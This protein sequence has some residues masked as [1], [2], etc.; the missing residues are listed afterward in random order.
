LFRLRLD[1]TVGCPTTGAWHHARQPICT[2]QS[3]TGRKDYE[4]TAREIGIMEL[5][6]LKRVPGLNE[7]FHL[8]QLGRSPKSKIAAIDARM[9]EREMTTVNPGDPSRA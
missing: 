1:P 5:V 4:L 8:T 9:D 6:D 2:A 7:L 3:G